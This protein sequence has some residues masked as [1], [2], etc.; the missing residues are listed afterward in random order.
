[1]SSARNA[2]HALEPKTH[3]GMESSSDGIVLGLVFADDNNVPVGG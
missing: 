2:V 3:N 1:M